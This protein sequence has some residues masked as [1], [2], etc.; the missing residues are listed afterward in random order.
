METGKCSNIEMVDAAKGLGPRAVHQEN[1]KPRD[2]I[3]LR[4]ATRLKDSGK[5]PSDQG[6]PRVR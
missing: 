1:F 4:S 5:C 2:E 3:S 6:G